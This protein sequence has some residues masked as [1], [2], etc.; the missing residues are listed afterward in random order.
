MPPRP[1]LN[2]IRESLADDSE[3]FEDI[4]LSRG[5]K[6]RFGALDPEA[7]L[8]RTPRGFDADHKAAVWL[9]YQSF[10][11]GCA[12]T[13]DEL[14]SAKLPSRL[15]NHYAAMLPMIRWLNT[16]LGLKPSS[17]R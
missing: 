5:F 14:Q 1:G 10:T 3:G 4:V 15:A 7:T 2:K 8:T 16:A 12:V 6:K 17:M 13:N 9:R 11:A